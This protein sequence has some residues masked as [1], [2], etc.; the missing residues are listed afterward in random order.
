MADESAQRDE[1]SM[2]TRYAPWKATIWI[3]LVALVLG[4]GWAAGAAAQ[5]GDLLVAVTGVDS[6]AFP[7]VTAYVSVLDENGLPVTGLATADVEVL[8]KGETPLQPLEVS[9]D[10][11]PAAALVLALDTSTQPESL[12]QVQQVVEAFL[13]ALGPED[14]V[15]LLAFADDVRVVLD[16]AGQERALAALDGLAAGGSY[17][18]LNEAAVRAANLASKAPLARRAAI[19]MTDSADNAG[20]RSLD[21]ALQGVRQAGAPVYLVGFGPKMARPEAQELLQI[22]G[23]AHGQSFVVPTPEEAQVPLQMISVL[24]HQGYKVT[25]RS[26]LQADNEKHPFTIGVTRPGQEGQT[27]GYLVALPG[28]VQVRVP[29]LEDG[30]E[31]GGVVNLAALVDAPAPV[32]S[33][34]YR[35]DGKLLAQVL[36]PPYALAWDSAAVEPGTHTLAVRA[37]DEAGNQGKVEMRLDV[38]RLVLVQELL[39]PGRVELGQALAVQAH[40]TALAELA[41][42]E[43]ALDG[44]PL[45]GSREDDAQEGT[46]RLS[47]DT[48][49]Y[50]P[51]PHVLTVRA[52]DAWGRSD[53]ASADVTFWGAAVRA[54]DPAP[55]LAPWRAWFRFPS[56]P[57]LVAA[58]TL[59]AAALAAAVLKGQAKRRQAIIPVEVYNEGNVRSRYR[60]RA[61][62]TGGDLQFRW[63]LNGTPLAPW[64]APDEGRDSEPVEVEVAPPPEPPARPARAREQAAAAMRAGDALVDTLGSVGNLLPGSMGRPMR[65]VRSQV[66]G[67]KSRVRRI[68]RTSSTL[69]RA[70]TRSSRPKARTQRRARARLAVLDTWCQTPAVEPGE[71][72]TVHL[73]AALHK[74]LARTREY[75]FRVIS[76]SLEPQDAPLETEEQRLRLVGVPWLRRLLPFVMVIGAAMIVAILLG[77]AGA[78]IVG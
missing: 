60:L 7:L 33:V 11:A 4:L 76:G 77:L 8:E 32:A 37:L 24:L 66:L 40:V 26:G 1:N 25:F 65:Q 34:E 78:G 9:G 17:T 46:Y 63:A 59:A 43:F 42:V 75:V 67:G 57:G 28:Q 45:D 29:G 72:L 38:V 10:A 27:E 12:A 39:A 13:N 49:G 58:S 61:E 44:R 6:R 41:Q 68:Q 50:A 30:Q 70:A 2:G 3:G 47:L 69:T 54:P 31:V 73:V 53:A 14:K 71:V 36:E 18:T 35:L 20:R 22:A 56:G 62:G 51:G 15:A 16:Y 52:E 55:P 74:P 48:T 5:G 23:A 21:E 64:R 19:I